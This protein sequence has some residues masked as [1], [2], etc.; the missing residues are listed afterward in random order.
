M[1]Q[2]TTFVPARKLRGA[3]GSQGSVPMNRSFEGEV[4]IDGAYFVGKV[5]QANRKEDRA[6][7]RAAEQSARSWLS[8]A[9][10]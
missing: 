7:R 5:R 8:P 4:A 3:I 1:Y 9:R 2:S 10:A 6:D